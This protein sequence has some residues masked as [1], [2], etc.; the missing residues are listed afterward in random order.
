MLRKQFAEKCLTRQII[1]GKVSERNYGTL[2]TTPF[3]RLN[4]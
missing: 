3:Y 2:G 4:N 1:E